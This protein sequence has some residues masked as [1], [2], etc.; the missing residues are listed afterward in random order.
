M[1]HWNMVLYFSTKI[2]KNQ[3]F[4]GEILYRE[5]ANDEFLQC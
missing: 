5:G 1:A 3:M 4:S 2:N